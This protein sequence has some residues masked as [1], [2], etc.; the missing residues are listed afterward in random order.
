ME[1]IAA[2]SVPLLEMEE[3]VNGA[4]MSSGGGAS[5]GTVG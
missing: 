4:V 5:S 2:V 1:L 3:N